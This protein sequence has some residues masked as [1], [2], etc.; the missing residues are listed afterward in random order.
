VQALTSKCQVTPKK[1]QRNKEVEKEEKEKK[2]ALFLVG[3]YGL[4]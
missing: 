3:C 1:K 4:F 2:N